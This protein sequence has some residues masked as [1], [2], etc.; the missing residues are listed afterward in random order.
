M[1]KNRKKTNS[2]F[3][4]VE[5]IFGLTILL[6]IFGAAVSFLQNFSRHS[7]SLTLNAEAKRRLQN[8]AEKIR[9]LALNN[10]D[11]FDV[12]AIEAEESSKK[13]QIVPTIHAMDALHRTRK[14]ELVAR[15]EDL[16]EV[17]ESSYTF[18]LTHLRGELEGAWAKIRVVNDFNDS[19]VDKVKI[20]T[21]GQNVREVECVTDSDGICI[22]G[23]MKISE[24]GI[25]L[26]V[27]GR[28]IMHFFYEGEG[29]GTGEY[30]KDFV[31]PKTELGKLH[32]DYFD[33]GGLWPHSH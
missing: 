20:K 26:E 30:I 12:E 11:E 13:I 1:M 21:E 22:L 29:P 28:D 32:L 7:V 4:M 10:F 8:T 23:G 19:P 3:S 25:F 24:T 15:W 14:V 6:I 17:K 5:I 33:G 18:T 31:L 9:L 2:G 27:D 16:G